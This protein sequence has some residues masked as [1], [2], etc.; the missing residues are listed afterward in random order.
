MFVTIYGQ[1][2]GDSWEDMMQVIYK[3]KHLAAQYQRIMA[4]SGDYSLEG[5][6]R[7]ALFTYIF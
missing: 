2:N 6:T 4:S 1:F 3:R 5:S 7:S